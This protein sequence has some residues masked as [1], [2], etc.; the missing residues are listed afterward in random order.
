MVTRS[1]AAGTGA[2]CSARGAVATGEALAAHVPVEDVQ[3]AELGRMLD[4][5][6]WQWEGRRFQVC[7]HDV[8]AHPDRYYSSVLRLSLAPAPRRTPSTRRLRTWSLSTPAESSSM[9]PGAA[10]WST[11]WT[12]TRW[13]KR[14][15]GSS[16]PGRYECVGAPGPAGHRRRTRPAHRGAAASSSVTASSRWRCPTTCGS[17]RWRCRAA[18]RNRAALRPRVRPDRIG[19]RAVSA[20]GLPR[21][22]ADDRL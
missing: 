17:G 18:P 4:L 19:D 12:R 8:A 13:I 11:P 9:T 15:G 7:P 5:P 1:R 6:L 3:V 14:G 22:T 2:N 16:L 20:L 21:G 10:R